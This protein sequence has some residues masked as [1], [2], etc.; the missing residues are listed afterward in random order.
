MPAEDLKTCPFCAETIKKKAIVCR[1][2]G[3]DLSQETVKI[4]LKDNKENGQNPTKKRSWKW[5]VITGTGI[6]A[7]CFFQIIC[8]SPTNNPFLPTITLTPTN[9][10][11][12]TI[13]NTPTKSRTPT[14]TPTATRKPTQTLTPTKTTL[15]VENSY[16]EIAQ[17][18]TLLPEGYKYGERS[19]YFGQFEGMYVR[20]WQ[21]RVGDIV[22]YFTDYHTKHI[23]VK[24]DGGNTVR[25]EVEQEVADM[26][27]VGQ[28]ITFSGKVDFITDIELYRYGFY[29]EIEDDVEI[30]EAQLPVE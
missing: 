30:L 22:K 1:Y 28:T 11:T 10:Y 18:A 13:T 5:L 12:V 20:N 23:F 14:V 16:L 21:G 2:C 3:R 9:T 6:L 27:S 19:Y 29:M 25:L 8:L 7:L 17:T 24:M 15:Y 4:V 26:L